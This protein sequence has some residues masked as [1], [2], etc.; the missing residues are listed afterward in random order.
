LS[1][2]HGG[3]PAAEEDFVTGSATKHRPRARR[4]R[5]RPQWRA[6]AERVWRW[7]LIGAA[8]LFTACGPLH[9]LGHVDLVYWTVLVALTLGVAAVPL[10]LFGLRR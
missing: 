5:P 9:A 2:A 1:G 8:G 10:G 7:P 3:A 6:L 4:R